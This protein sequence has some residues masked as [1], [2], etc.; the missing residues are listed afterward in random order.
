MAGKTS[1][2]AHYDILVYLFDRLS[3]YIKQ[4]LPNLIFILFITIGQTTVNQTKKKQ[5]CNYAYLLFLLFF[6]YRYLLLV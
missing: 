1:Y 5:A 3:K 4:Y 2:E 6:S